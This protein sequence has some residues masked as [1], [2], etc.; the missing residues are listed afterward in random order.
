MGIRL[1]TQLLHAL[2]VSKRTVQKIKKKPHPRKISSLGKASFLPHPM[3]THFPTHHLL[4]FLSLAP[5][6]STYI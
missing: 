2:V 5:K 1:D 6:Y 3:L 4:D